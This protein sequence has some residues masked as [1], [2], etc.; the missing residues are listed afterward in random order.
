MD[1]SIIKSEHDLWNGKVGQTG[2]TLLEMLLV[3]FILLTLTI[4][5][6]Q[7]FKVLTSWSITPSSL[8]PFEWEVAISQLT[9]DIREANEIEIENERLIL[10][11]RENVLYEQYGQV[12]R[13]RV[14]HL[15]HEI[16]LQNIQS[17]QF[18]HIQ[19]GI[20]VEVEDLEG[21]KYER[22]IF[23]WTNTNG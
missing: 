21:K 23:T 22:K 15:G 9:M 20:K 19:D 8:H 18:Y 16:I 10:R 6:P 13:R 2:H 7:F 12:L 5:F 17:V 3:I 1:K 4:T 14:N 11:S